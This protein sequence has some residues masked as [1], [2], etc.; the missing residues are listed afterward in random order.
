MAEGSRVPEPPRP[1]Y[2]GFSFQGWYMD[3]SMAAPWSFAFDKVRGD[4]TLRA[5]WETV[6]GPYSQTY[7]VHFD[8][9]GGSYISPISG[10]DYDAII[11][12]PADPVRDGFA[13][14]GWYKEAACVNPWSFQSDHILEDTTI[15]A[16]WDR[17]MHSVSFDSMG[18]TPVPPASVAHSSLVPPPE[19]PERDGYAFSG[20]YADSACEALWTFPVDRVSGDATLYAKWTP[21]PHVARLDY[22]G[23]DGDPGADGGTMSLREGDPYM[24]PLPVRSVRAGEYRF[25][26][27]YTGMGGVNSD[28]STDPVPQSGEWPFS[29]EVEL[30]A[31][32]LGTEGLLYAPIGGGECEASLGGADPRGEIAVQEWFRGMRVSRIADGAFANKTGITGVYIPDAVAEI[33]EY[34]FGGC[35]GISSIALP[36]GLRSLCE[37]AFSN[38]MAAGGP[39]ILPEALE[40]I[41]DGAFFA[42]EAITGVITFPESLRSLGAEAFSYCL[43]ISGADMSAATIETIPDSA[44]YGCASLESVS[45]PA[46]LREIGARAFEGC[47]GIS[48][49]SLPDGLEKAGAKAFSGCTGM[50]RMFIPLGAAMGENAVEGCGPLEVY[51]AAEENLTHPFVPSGW[52]PDWMG[53]NPVGIE[54]HWGSTSLP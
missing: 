47:T 23:A 1:E 40:A 45:W 14:A 9:M 22:Q 8:S 25:G 44:F 3:E 38:C 36:P 49:L 24:L 52:S 21:M 7:T 34:A 11:A 6:G 12:R 2:P 17:V 16:G 4:M 19:Q 27:W 13:F 5:K 33:G 26:G 42:C 29:R 48:E 10:V 20:W 46:G 51:A 39:L 28:L 15:Y 37:G 53:E 31:Y 32:W 30:H 43:L 41:G 54:V 18:G 50:E 35:T